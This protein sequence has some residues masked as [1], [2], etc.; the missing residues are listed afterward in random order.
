MRVADIVTASVLLLVSGVV[1]FDAVRL[2]IGWSTDGPRSGFLPFWLGVLMIAVCA[3]IVAQA[4]RR[5]DAPRGRRLANIIPLPGRHLTR[6]CC[7]RGLSASA[8]AGYLWPHRS[9]AASAGP[10]AEAQGVRWMPMTF[11]NAGRT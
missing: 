1:V 5:A 9:A 6:A 3:V 7:W 10:A 2:G 11:V 4:A 8:A